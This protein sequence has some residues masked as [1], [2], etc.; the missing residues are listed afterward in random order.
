MTNQL[1]IPFKRT[2]AI[3]LT[4]T[5][6]NHIKSKSYN[7]HPDAFKWD[8]SKWEELRKAVANSS[9]HVNQVDV[10]LE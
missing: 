5:V 9:V 4:D 8:L 6:Y 2:Y 7:V 3:P 10:I 1:S